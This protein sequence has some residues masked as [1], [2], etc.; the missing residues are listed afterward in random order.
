MSSNGPP[1]MPP[2][3]PF[4]DR[5]PGLRA[6]I[7]V[8]MIVSIISVLLRFWSRTLMTK[9]SRG[10]PRIWWDDWLA[11]SAL[12][13]ILASG[14]VM[15]DMIRLGLGKHTWVIPPTELLPIMN[16]LFAVYFLYN[17]G[18]T[19]AKASGLVFYQRVF[20]APTM[21]KWFS[22]SLTVMHAINFGP[23]IGNIYLI[24]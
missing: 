15:L 5:G 13:L 2:G 17:S 9:E 18:L 22:R 11:L 4:D 16:R 23:Y 7:I 6:F 24:M 3:N 8:M 20:S 19:F 12:P 10:I 21:Y 14:V 1:K